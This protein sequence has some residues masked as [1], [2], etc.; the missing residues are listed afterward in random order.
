MTA[1]PP[2]GPDDRDPQTGDEPG[3]ADPF[4]ALGGLFGPG[5]LGSMQVLLAQAQQMQTDLAE[6][7]QRLAGTH[8]SGTSGGGLV[9]ATVTGD[10]EL[11]GLTIDPSVVDPADTETL[12]DLVV[13]AVR[14]ANEHARTVGEQAMAAQLP[15]LSGVDLGA[16]GG[17]GGI[18]GGG[19]GG[20]DRADFGPSVPGGAAT[21]SIPPLVPDDPDDAYSDPEAGDGGG[22]GQRGPHV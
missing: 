10:R 4:A 19:A 12:A 5:G 8:V 2:S 15:D 22:P 6:T 7:Q 14:A 1:Q 20:S 16:L 3:E 21:A 13:A 17:L 9:R 11:V 18:G